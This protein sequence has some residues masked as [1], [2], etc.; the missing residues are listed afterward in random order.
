LSLD[1][2][3]NEYLQYL[4]SVGL[5]GL[6]AYLSIIVLI[7]KKCIGKL[8]SNAVAMS[9]L[10]GLVAYWIQAV[11]NIAQPCTTPLMFL[12]IAILS[13][14]TDGTCVDE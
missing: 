4:I 3:H 14:L 11:V 9:I 8:Q 1:Q 10:C 13:K 6:T 7:V 12:F 2:V 5:F